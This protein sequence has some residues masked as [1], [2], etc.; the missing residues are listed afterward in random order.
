MNVTFWNFP[1]SLVVTNNKNNVWREGS[2]I[3]IS[4]SHFSLTGFR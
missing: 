2:K 1:T 3:G 4:K